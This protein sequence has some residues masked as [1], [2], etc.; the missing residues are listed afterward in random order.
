VDVEDVCTEEAEF[1]GLSRAYKIVFDDDEKS[2]SSLEGAS[3]VFSNFAK[4]T[5]GM[6]LNNCNINP[7]DVHFNQALGTYTFDSLISQPELLGRRV[8]GCLSFD[9]EHPA[10]SIAIDNETFNVKLISDI[11]WFDVKVSHNAGSY[12]GSNNT[13]MPNAGT[14]EWGAATWQQSMRF[15]YRLVKLP[16]PGIGWIYKIENYF[17]DTCKHSSLVL[18]FMS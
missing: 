18:E 16:A 6:N 4:E 14:V 12:M 7:K 15:G 3:I 10:G 11:L 2:N 8:A 5:G 13:L 1:H 9:S 17:Q